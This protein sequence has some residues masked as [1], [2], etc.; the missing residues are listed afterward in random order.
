MSLKNSN[1]SG[2]DNVSPNIL[3]SVAH[4][5]KGPLTYLVNWSLSTGIFPNV[6]KTAKVVP[7][8]KKG[9]QS[10]VENYRP[11]SMLSTISKILERVVFNR[12]KLF[13]NKY[14]ILNSAQ[15]GFREG[16]STQT[17]ILGFL[18]SLYQNLDNNKK[19]LG[20]FMDLSKAFDLVDHA[21]LIN[22]LEKYGFR[23]RLGS[24]LRSYLSD[25]KQIVEIDGKR[26]NPLEVTCGVP[27]GSI[28]GP[29]LFIIFINDLPNIVNCTDLTMFADDNSYLS[30]HSSLPDLVLQTQEKL[31]DFVLWFQTNGLLI[32]A[33]KTV[34]MLFS[35]KSSNTAESQLIKINHKSIEQVH[36]TKFLGVYIDSTLNWEIHVDNLCKKLSSVCFALYRLKQVASKNIVLS[37]Y[38][39][40]FFSRIA[41]GIVFWGSSNFAV[42]VFKVQ[43]KAVRNIA[44]VSKFTSCRE[45]FKKYQI[46]TLTSLYVLETV[47]FVKQNLVEFLNNNFHHHYNTRGQDDLLTP[48]HSLALYEK[49]PYYIGIQLYNKLPDSI[50]EISSKIIFKNR[51]KKLLLDG[52]F[53]SLNEFLEY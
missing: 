33:T 30:I 52:T 18:K 8:Y 9:I 24:W 50:K 34:F 7:L 15:H 36:S 47:C 28:L 20:L 31:N 40:Q 49:S 2:I 38:Y 5:V 14:N 39:A 21:L 46:L 35:P 4:F 11:I 12:M 44:G 37:Y 51:V 22:K 53:Y 25:R 42:R 45:L 41:Y 10:C 16:K 17:A 13:L 48:L 26:S 27:Q 29:L 32:N 19:C 6:L 3:K 43:K 1:S 23:G